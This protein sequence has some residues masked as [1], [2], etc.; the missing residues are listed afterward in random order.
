M[1]EAK[2]RNRDVMVFLLIIGE[3]RINGEK[4]SEKR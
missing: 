4:L 1:P 3:E 2:E